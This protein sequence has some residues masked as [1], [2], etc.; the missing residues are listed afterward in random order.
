[1]ASD[2]TSKHGFTISDFDAL[3]AAT[4]HEQLCRSE[5]ATSVTFFSFLLYFVFLMIWRLQVLKLV[6]VRTRYLHVFNDAE[7]ELNVFMFWIMP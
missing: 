5:L 3:N 1:M 7:A 4:M 6:N 2:P